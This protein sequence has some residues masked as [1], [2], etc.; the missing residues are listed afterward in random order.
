MNEVTRH[1][2]NAVIGLFR[3]DRFDDV[4]VFLKHGGKPENHVI[5][6]GRPRK[7]VDKFR[8]Q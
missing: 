7:V 1:A 5:A 3:R 4:V 8:S 2:P 6:W